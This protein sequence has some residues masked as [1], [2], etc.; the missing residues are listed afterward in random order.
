MIQGDTPFKAKDVLLTAF[1]DA[2]KQHATHWQ[3]KDLLQ[4][5]WLKA[6]QWI[7]GQD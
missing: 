7:Q 3:N 2:A 6:C 4:Y 1:K 5:D